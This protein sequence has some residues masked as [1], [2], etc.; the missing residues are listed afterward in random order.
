[1]TIDD[2]FQVDFFLIGSGKSATTWLFRCLEDHPELAIARVK[3]PQF[4]VKS[5]DPY[6]PGEDP[7]DNDRFLDDRDWYR[8]QFKHAEPGQLLGDLSIN[9]LHNLDTAP[10]LLHDHNPDARLL[11]MLR[12]PAERTYSM[13]WHQRFHGD[14]P[15]TVPDT[16]EAWLEDERHIMSSRYHTLLQRWLEV[17]P[18]DQL[19]V[20]TVLDLKED[21]AALVRDVY[22]FLD[23][24]PGFE[25]EALHE[26][27]N[28]AHRN[29]PLYE[30][31]RS[32]AETL[33]R[34]GFGKVVDAVNAV[35]LGK[36]IERVGTE[37]VRYP[38]M[39]AGTERELRETFLPE[40]EGLEE[41]LGRD[42]SA[43]KPGGERGDGADQDGDASPTA[44][45]TP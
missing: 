20:R 17:W 11:A 10:E 21:P 40:V 34:V 8:D 12:D 16:F 23:V 35:G 2:G 9:L 38:P 3:E 13:Y 31:A 45:G 33:H 25:P 29:R 28:P 14:D 19:Q 30:W 27:V 42:L 32:A 41:L 26:R 18:R 15:D 5:R 39:D 1:M 22:A 43:W 6:L 36:L 4:F 24:D 44:G 7:E 37:R